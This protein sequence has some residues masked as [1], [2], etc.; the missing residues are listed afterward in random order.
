MLLSHVP[1]HNHNHHNSE[2]AALLRSMIADRDF[3]IVIIRQKI[4]DLVVKQQRL[5]D[6]LDDATEQSAKQQI[7]N[8]S[9]KTNLLHL[10]QLTTEQLHHV[11][12]DLQ[13]QGSSLAA[14]ANMTNDVFIVS[15][16]SSGNDPNHSGGVDQ[17]LVMRMQAQLCKAMHSMGILDHQFE[18]SQA[19]GQDAIKAL[20]DVLTRLR[21]AKTQLELNL[22]NDLMAA[23]I[24]KREAEAD[25]K[26]QVNDLAKQVRQLQ[27]KLEN[28]ENEQEQHNSE[29]DEP[30]KNKDEDFTETENPDEDF[31]LNKTKQDMLNLLEQR[32]QQIKELEKK[33][34]AQEEELS[35]LRNTLG[36]DAVQAPEAR[37]PPQKTDS[38]DAD[39]EETEH[40][41]ESNNNDNMAMRLRQVMENAKLEDVEKAGA[42]HELDLLKMAQNRLNR[43]L[44]ASDGESSD[45]EDEDEE[46]EDEEDEDEDHDEEQEQNAPDEEDMPPK[47][48]GKKSSAA[49]AFPE[50]EEKTADVDESENHEDDDHE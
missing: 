31:E 14:Y 43:P 28:D 24:L 26:K 33:L 38:E 25:F 41:E 40:P 16:S 22:L 29:H 36:E 50:K 9:E 13:K 42:V 2:E 5:L 21:E 15:D 32:N 17:H 1:M 4:S 47:K 11:E 27:K 8:Q 37:P 35:K 30:S 46:D 45:E 6:E 23:D 18:M 19:L 12:D 44:P 34:D 7:S 48:E 3:R 49:P 20:R 39:I 10:E